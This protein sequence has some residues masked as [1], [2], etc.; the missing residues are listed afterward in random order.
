MNK[1]TILV[2][3]QLG[4]DNNGELAIT[5]AVKNTSARDLP[6]WDLRFDFP[7]SVAAGPGTALDWRVGSHICL[8]SEGRTTLP[9]GQTATLQLTCPANS[10]QRLGDLPNGL[11]IQSQGH[12]IA[13]ELAGHNFCRP[14]DTT[15]PDYSYHPG[16]SG[17]HR[18][19]PTR[20]RGPEEP[21]PIIPAPRQW[22]RGEGVF[23]TGEKLCIHGPDEAG[24]A[25]AW[26]V[27]NTSAQPVTEQADANIVFIRD[28]SQEDGAYVLEVSPVGVQIAASGPSGWFHGASSLVQLLN[29]PA[30]ELGTLP[31]LK[32]ID[33]PRFGYRGFMLDCARHFHEKAVVLRILDY[34]ALYKLNH[35]HWHLT[36][37]EG[38]RLEI[39][40]YPELT[41]TGAWRGAAEA[42]L[43]QF[44]SGIDRYGGYYSQDDVREILAYA[45]ARQINV[46]PEIDIPGHSRAA[47]R[48]L[49][50]L[51]VERAD[52]SRYCSVQFYDDNVLNPGL[53]GTYEFLH[54]VLDEVCD[55]FPSPWVHIGGDEVPQGVWQHSPACQALMEQHGYDGA[56]D[57]Q[58]HL[59]RDTQA[60]LQKKGRQLIGW[61]E[62]AHGEKLESSATI[63]AWSSIEAAITAGE[64]GY[65][66]IGC[67]APWA[68]LDMAWS[69]DIHEP[70]FHWAGTAD[71]EA[72]YAYEPPG[73]D[74]V[75]TPI[76]GTQT[77]L[78]SELIT[79][80]ER[81]DYMLFPRLLA[82][83]E[84][85]WS[86]PEVKDW[87]GFRGRVT[88]QLNW[89]ASRGVKPRPSPD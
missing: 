30:E 1:N 41:G 85:A 40:A 24:D 27:T 49:P 76:I 80:P 70:G 25:S 28:A 50:A 51:L 36:D 19:S 77:L 67:P 5:L 16:P 14:F 82:G 32:V 60:Y 20:L 26:L 43:P 45:Q 38:W 81:L 75:D 64:A 63:C 48:S 15:A 65:G 31:C 22:Q 47:I 86:H 83:A 9:A 10:V 73:A 12:F 6:E 58:G 74:Q 46:I 54:T 44:G 39:L 71:L 13:A 84:T 69:P 62:A 37:D 78:W 42:L 68:Y 79:S 72:C 55:L 35:F 66:V 11:Y 3:A 61:E 18:E 87:P 33:V 59:F 56:L 53:P 2:D 34:M 17:Q 23:R 88:W 29:A 89:L 21:L 57:L 52:K 4:L 8:A 7:K